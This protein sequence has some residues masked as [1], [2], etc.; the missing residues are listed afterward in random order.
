MEAAAVSAAVVPASAAAV[1]PASVAPAVVVLS[2]LPQA[3]SIEAAIKAAI[4]QAKT[5]FFITKSSLKQSSF[6]EKALRQ[7]RTLAVYH[8]S[9]I[10]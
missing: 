7:F 1:V 8:I 9:T 2:P 10:K 6:S 4:P 3:D 5:F